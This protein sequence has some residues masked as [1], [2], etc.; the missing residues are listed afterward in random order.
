M[1]QAESL[2]NQSVTIIQQM[3][4]MS[5]SRSKDHDYTLPLLKNVS[6]VRGKIIEADI[7][8]SSLKEENIYFKI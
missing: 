6:I 3:T 7:G 4:F 1:C 2:N 5:K 8:F